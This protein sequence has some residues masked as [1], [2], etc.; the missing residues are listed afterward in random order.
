MRSMPVGAFI[1]YLPLS[2]RSAVQGAAAAGEEEFLGT[3]LFLGRGI[4][5]LPLSRGSAASWIPSPRR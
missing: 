3:S 4:P 5:Y 1:P 2:R